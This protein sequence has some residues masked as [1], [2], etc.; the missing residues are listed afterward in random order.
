MQYMKCFHGIDRMRFAR[1]LDLDLENNLPSWY[2]SIALLLSAVMLP[3]IGLH[4]SG[5]AR[6]FARHWLALAIL[7]LC[8]SVD[9]VASIHE[10]SEGVYFAGFRLAVI[11]TR[12]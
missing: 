7:F 5:R 2:S 9:E 1:L 10:M 6:K 4:H 11:S 3:I 8:L 12:R